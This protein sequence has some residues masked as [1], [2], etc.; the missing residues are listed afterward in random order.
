MI[1]G[2]NESEKSGTYF[3]KLQIVHTSYYTVYSYM[4]E[5]VAVGT[6]KY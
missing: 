6:Q 5:L 4:Y 2:A 1:Q 3:G